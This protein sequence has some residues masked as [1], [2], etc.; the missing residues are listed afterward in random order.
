MSKTE[1]R[2][3]YNPEDR[4][5]KKVRKIKESKKN[6]TKN[7]RVQIAIR[8]QEEEDELLDN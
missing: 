6:G 5:A 2:I 1:R 8:E 4:Y 7:Q 3:D